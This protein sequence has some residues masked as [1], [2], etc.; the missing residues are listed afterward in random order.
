[1][2]FVI[3]ISIGF[4]AGAIVQMFIEDHNEKMIRRWHDG[5]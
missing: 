1:M 4:V 2:W 5:V 3:G